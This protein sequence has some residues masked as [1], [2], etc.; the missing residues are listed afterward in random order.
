MMAYDCWPVRKHNIDDKLA[1]YTVKYITEIH[2][3][4]FARHACT[5]FHFQWHRK[6][7]EAKRKYVEN[8]LRFFLQTQYNGV[9]YLFN[10]HMLCESS[11]IF[12]STRIVYSTIFFHC[13]FGMY[14][15]YLNKSKHG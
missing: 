3:F 7:P 14:I 9:N 4:K 6:K 2:I 8:A 11:S 10:T 15:L 5:R 13:V 12:R 1:E